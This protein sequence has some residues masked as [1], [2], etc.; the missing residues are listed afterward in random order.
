MKTYK[1]NEGYY[2]DKATADGLA[3]SNNALIYTAYAKALGIELDLKEVEYQNSIY[4]SH[5]IDFIAHRINRIDETQPPFSKDEFLGMVIL[6]TNEKVVD[7][8][9]KNNWN[10]SKHPKVTNIF[11]TLKDLYMLRKEHRNYVWKERVYSVYPKAFSV[12]YKMRY[13]TRAY[14]GDSVNLFYMLMFYI[15]VVTT[16]AFSSAGSKNMLWLQLT[17]LNNPLAKLVNYKK[18]FLE[19][20]GKDHTFNKVINNE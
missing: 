7:A 18:N 6:K 12:P 16:L 17:M 10:F 11:T 3:S 8:V 20:F 1:D 9:V 15:G 13:F 2:H 4:A 14:R 19:Y 5:E